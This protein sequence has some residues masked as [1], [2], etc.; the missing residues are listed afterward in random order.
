LARAGLENPISDIFQYAGLISQGILS[1]RD[2]RK[3]IALRR[4]G[5]VVSDLDLRTPDA[6][7]PTDYYFTVPVQRAILENYRPLTS[8]ELPSPER[9][10]ADFR[11]YVWVPRHTASE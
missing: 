10:Q 4:F 6:R 2:L 3:Q 7:L 11:F 8:L 5:L 1:D 9:H